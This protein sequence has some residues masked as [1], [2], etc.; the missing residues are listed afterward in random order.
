MVC[1]R[2]IG[3]PSRPPSGHEPPGRFSAGNAS[4]TPAGATS[5]CAPAGT[6]STPRPGVARR[7]RASG[8]G[9]ALPTLPGPQPLP[10]LPCPTGQVG[11]GGMGVL[12]W[13]WGSPSGLGAV[14]LGQGD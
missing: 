8:R 7:D 9:A 12:G 1:R 14:G 11:C 5:G 10:W 6:G 13:G 4:G 2:S 3:P